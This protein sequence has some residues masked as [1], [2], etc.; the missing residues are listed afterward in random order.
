MS[1]GAL[2]DVGACLGCHKRP[3]G[4]SA[5][6]CHD[7]SVFLYA[8]DLLIQGRAQARKLDSNIALSQRGGEFCSPF[9][10]KA[11][12]PQKSRDGRV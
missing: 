7:D 4:A 8:F 3:A 11:A 5:T 12:V 6:A 1:V 2:N 9:R 10:G